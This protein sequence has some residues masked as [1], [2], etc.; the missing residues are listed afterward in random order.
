MEVSKKKELIV[1]GY[2][3]EKKKVLSIDI[4]DDIIKII[5]S[6][7]LFFEWDKIKSHKGFEIN[8]TK[9]KRLDLGGGWISA[10][11]INRIK[12]MKILN[13]E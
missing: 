4:P 9:I 7:C 10:F 3:N 5:E 2:M 11:S 12:Q 6:F 8:E 13:G 1:F